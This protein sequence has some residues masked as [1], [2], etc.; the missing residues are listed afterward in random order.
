MPFRP[1]SSLAYGAFDAADEGRRETLLTQGNGKLTVRAAACWATADA[2]HYPGTYHAGFYNRLDDVIQGERMTNESLVNLPNW[3]PLTFRVLGETEWFALERVEILAYDHRLNTG[4][5][6]AERMVLFR[7]QA[8]RCTRLLEQRLVSM[9]R[10]DLAALRLDITPMDWSGQLE[11]RA[12][13]DGTV[14]N[15]RVARFQRFD[16]QH[17]HRIEG[18]VFAPGLLSLSAETRGSGSRIAIATRLRHAGTLL[19]AGLEVAGAAERILCE[20]SAGCTTRLEKTA[21]IVT[22]LDLEGDCSQLDPTAAAL[23]LL[24]DAADFDGL[25]A[26][27]ADAWAPLLDRLGISDLP[28]EL[29]CSLRFHACHLLQTAS[30]HSLPL[31]VGFPARGWQEAYRGHIF[32][33]ETFVLPFFVYRYPKIAR[34]LLLYRC[35]RLPEAREAARA[36]GYRGAMFPWRSGADGREHTPILQFN[37][38][39]GGWIEDHTRLQRHIGA[40]IAYNIW[41]Y[42]LATG[43]QPF[44]IEHGARM[45]LEIA[46]FWGSIARHDPA[47]DRYD[48]T[49]VSG[50]DEYHTGY[51][52]AAAQGVANNAYTNVMAAW[53]LARA[54]EVLAML[55][56]PDRAALCSDMQLEPDELARWDRISRRL[57]L[58]FAA[59]GTLLPFAGFDCLLP[60][61]LS[62]LQREHGDTRLDWAL[63]AQGDDLCRYQVMKQADTQVLAFLLPHGELE[64]MLDRLGYPMTP[65]AWRRTLSHDLARTS[66]ESS[67]SRIA[68]A[69]ALT[70]A[71]P[72]T[73]WKFFTAALQ[74]EHDPSSASAVAEGAHLGAYGAAIGVL[75][76]HYLGFGVTPTG[77]RLEPAPPPDM[78]PVTATLDSRFGCFTLSWD[79]A[80]LRLSADAGNPAPV[81]VRLPG[82]DTVLAPGH[83]IVLTLP[84]TSGAAVV[85]A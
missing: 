11:I 58:A 50:P 32:W 38:L 85:S 56:G 73:S 9:A 28:G 60:A 8:G 49:G 37:M 71:D 26:A 23:A 2:V 31:D 39:S 81:A 25:A 41:H 48:I 51:P 13:I 82:R 61:K 24:Q 43:D 64:R 77:I 40:S 59:D 78:P 74:P 42:L 54:P 65:A 34:Q 79:R 55:P 1:P 62:D 7:D 75:Q 52:G 45:M 19:D 30:P 3:L 27:H 16:R 17:L 44:L 10:P 80:Q 29:G 63:H 5:G 53:V 33:D 84:E 35:Q 68:F 72:A 36:H 6:L 12:A 76:H 66:H 69:G 18:Q 70:H 47:D 20:V 4:T 67:L 14:S 15:D 21:A 83:S 22:S 46:R 57:R